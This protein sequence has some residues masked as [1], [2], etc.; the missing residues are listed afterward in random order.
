MAWGMEGTQMVHRL[1]RLQKGCVRSPDLNGPFCESSSAA[2]CHR[3]SQFLPRWG[4]QPLVKRVGTSGSLFS[5]QN[6]SI[7][8]MVTLEDM[9][10]LQC[11]TYERRCRIQ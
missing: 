10:F 1:T 11:L 5:R 7:E 3:R 6:D 9:Q 4:H 2:R 8:E